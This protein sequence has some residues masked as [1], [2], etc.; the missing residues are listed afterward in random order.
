MQALPLARDGPSIAHP[1]SHPACRLLRRAGTLL[2]FGAL[3]YQSFAKKDAK[4][5]AKA[6]GVGS[7]AREAP[8]TPDLEALKPL[9]DDLASKKEAELK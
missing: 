8:P 2:V 4:H 6:H 9:L 3:Y 1:D 5:G 7:P